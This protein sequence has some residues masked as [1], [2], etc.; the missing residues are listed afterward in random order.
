MIPEPWIKLIPTDNSG[1][2]TTI[3]SQRQIRSPLNLILEAM[4]IRGYLVVMTVTHATLGEFV[5]A[6]VKHVML[7]YSEYT[8]ASICIQVPLYQVGPT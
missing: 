1:D 8:W 4:S 7:V 2:K 6:T 3:K 5:V